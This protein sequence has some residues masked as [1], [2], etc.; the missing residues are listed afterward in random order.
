[1]I[2][3]NGVYYDLTLSPYKTTLDGYTYVFSSRLH[4]EKFNRQYE[5]HRKKIDFSLSNRFNLFVKFAPLA[6]VVLYSK[7]ETRGFLM[8]DNEG[9]KLCKNNIILSG[10]KLTKKNFH[11]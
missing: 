11:E 2:T 8:F 6:D 3:R 7:V 5:E 4:M 9:N 1:M 10:V